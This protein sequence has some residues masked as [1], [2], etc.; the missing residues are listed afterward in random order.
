MDVLLDV[1]NLKTYFHTRNGIVKAV[2]GVSFQVRRGETMAL[3]G[4]SGSGKSMTVLSIMRLVP[5]PGR[6]V[7][8]Q[9]LFDGQDLFQLGSAQMCHI[10]GS[11]ISMVFQEPTAHL[12]PVLCVGRQIAEVLTTHRGVRW[13]AALRRAQELLSMVR[14]PDAAQRSRQYSHQLS[15]G[16]CQRVVIAMSMACSPQL[17]IADEPTTALDVTV[18]A[19]VLELIKALTTNFGTSVI[20]VT[21][22]LGIVADWAD[23]INVMYLGRIVESA[24]RDELYYEP[25]HP[26]TIGLLDSVPR[27][28]R[29][30]EA[31][32]RAIEGAPP[33]PEHPPS[34]CAFHPRCHLATE[35]CAQEAPPLAVVDGKEH[36]CA[37]WHHCAAN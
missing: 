24:P 23:R 13:S 37:C 16:M 6:I 20:L 14:I 28:D 18:E 21:H 31:R 4:E 35:R 7:Q 36:W 22:N 29:P 17:L 32:L 11:R 33:D 19:Q 12:N 27:L 30:R 9:V 3:V 2:D 5:A 34:G 1:R 8:G 26:Y 15:G 25:R 10:R